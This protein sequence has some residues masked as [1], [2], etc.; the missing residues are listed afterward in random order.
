MAI[1]SYQETI[2]IN[3]DYVEAYYYL[4]I[5]YST[6]DQPDKAI[7]NFLKTI[8]I[9]P[10]YIDA[11]YNIAC[12]YSLQED[13]NEALIWL[14]KSLKKGMVNWEHIASDTDL[15]NIRDLDK[16]KELIDKYKE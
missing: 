4:G 2:K 1:E 9:N 8:E 12:V 10:E 7:K 3:P 5:L 16:Y 15:N 13:T 6:I 11:Y 14:E